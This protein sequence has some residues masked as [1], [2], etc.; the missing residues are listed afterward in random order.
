MQ[1]IIH[2][3]TRTNLNEDDVAVGAVEGEAD[4]VPDVDVPDLVVA[5]RGAADQPAGEG[6]P[7]PRVP[8][9]QEGVGVLRAEREELELGRLTEG[10]SMMSF[11]SGNL[12]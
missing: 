7:R 12:I 10:W 9:A 6:A 3:L 8:E 4:V 11:F 2:L 5:G 1:A